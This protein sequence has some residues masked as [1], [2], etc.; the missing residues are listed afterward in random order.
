MT[1][2]KSIQIIEFSGKTEDFDRGRQKGHHILLI[3]VVLRVNKLAGTSPVI[4][5]F[6]HYELLP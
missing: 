1:D 5:F 4:N 2:E 3:G 6:P